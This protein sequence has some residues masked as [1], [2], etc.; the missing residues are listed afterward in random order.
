MDNIGRIDEVFDGGVVVWSV[1]WFVIWFVLGR[2]EIQF[3]GWPYADK[4][5]LFYIVCGE[6]P[7]I[8]VI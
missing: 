8:P 4:P 6:M 1:V 3:D 2:T 5:G 7:N